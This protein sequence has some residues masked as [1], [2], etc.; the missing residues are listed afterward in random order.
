M[1]AQLL[2]PQKKTDLYPTKYKMVRT[3]QRRKAEMQTKTN[4]QC[5][6]M[7]GMGNVEM[8]NVFLTGAGIPKAIF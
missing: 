1:L 2:S 7:Q 5:K 4:K 8:R 3:A 6:K